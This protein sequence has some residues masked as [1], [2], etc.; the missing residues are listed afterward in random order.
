MNERQ[1]HLSSIEDELPYLP[2]Q[3]DLS[4][5]QT[6]GMLLTDDQINYILKE[7]QHEQEDLKE[8]SE[9]KTVVD[10]ALLKRGLI[11]E[12]ET[13]ESQGYRSRILKKKFNADYNVVSVRGN[14]QRHFFAIY[15]G[16][17]EGKSLGEGAFGKVKLAQDIETGKW[18][19]LKILNALDQ[20]GE[21]EKDIVHSAITEKE[22]INTAGDTA[23][24]L[25]RCNLD[26]KDSTKLK[27]QGLIIM[28]L[29]HGKR[30]GDI[31]HNKLSS[32]KWLQLAANSAKALKKL[33]NKGLYHR[34]IKPSN[35]IANLL[36][37]EVRPVD[38]G[39][40]TSFRDNKRT[41]NSV[42][43]DV[44]KGTPG[45]IAPELNNKEKYYTEKTEVF[46]L[47]KTIANMLG[48]TD[49]DVNILDKD[50]PAL[51]KNQCIKEKEVRD[52]LID[53][54]KKMT[55][56]DPNDR[57]S[58]NEAMVFF[59]EIQ[60]LYNVSQTPVKNTGVFDINEY[61]SCSKEKRK[62]MVKALKCC[63]EV[64]VI[65][66]GTHTRKQYIDFRSNLEKAGVPVSNKLFQGKN[67]VDVLNDIPQH[68]KDKDEE[69]VRN[70]FFIT[71]HKNS[72]H[73]LHADI[74][75][76]ISNPSKSESEYTKCI[77]QSLNEKNL[78]QI[79][80]PYIK[81]SL[82][83]EI[84]RL[85]KKHKH[86]EADIRINAIQ[87][88]ISKLQ[89]EYN[90]QTLTRSNYVEEIEKLQKKLLVTDTIRA[91]LAKWLP[92]TKSDNEKLISN[93]SDVSVRRRF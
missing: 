1:T 92:I 25:T 14:N 20:Y 67:V 19:A 54:L 61:E 60:K 39:L 11:K 24:I 53:Y 75:P 50:N 13:F 82:N 35:L 78:V 40:A 68:M 43:D 28:D 5:I 93:L 18:Y 37:G 42:R 86:G 59:E 52:V 89:D 85:R 88:T 91:T 48:L 64:F 49:K 34:D 26:T 55:A 27:S 22:R 87:S 74:T 3:V 21:V 9:Q 65:D 56:H 58:L 62:A 81:A 4:D 63:D 16:S 29:A 57:P 73:E 12:G 38:F 71:N 6:N 32:H 70:Y 23:Y 10:K 76:L 83:E 79:N 69:R 45:Y 77:S 84:D 8:Y 46:A 15:K 44:T 90:N 17:R 80:F 51:E 31:P 41:D 30:L 33:H 66:T 47:G 7:Y 72:Y 2:Q 36:T